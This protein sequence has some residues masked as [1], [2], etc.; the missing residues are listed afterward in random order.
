M[1]LSRILPVLLTAAIVAAWNWDF[2]SSRGTGPGPRRG[3]TMNLYESSGTRKAILCGGIG[4]DAVPTASCAVLNPFDNWNFFAEFSM[5]TPRTDAV[6]VL[7]HEGPL[8]YLITWGGTPKLS[9]AD[10]C[11]IIVAQD[12]WEPAVNASCTG[13]PPSATWGTTL[14]ATASGRLVFYGGATG[15]FADPG[16]DTGDLYTMSV[17][18]QQPLQ[19]AWG[20]PNMAVTDT[21]TARH[22]HAAAS[23]GETVVIFGGVTVAGA[24]LSDVW[25]LCTDCTSWEWQL[26]TTSGAPGLYGHN[27]VIT[28]SLFVVYGGQQP[29]PTGIY[30]SPVSSRGTWTFTSPKVTGNAPPSGFGSA[31]AL[32]AADG[33]SDPDLVVYGGSTTSSVGS[34][35]SSSLSVLSDIGMSP[36]GVE[37][38]LPYIIGGATGAL[39]LLGGI[40]ICAYQ[41]QKRPPGL[42]AQL[43]SMASKPYEHLSEDAEA[44]ERQLL[45]TPALTR[46]NSFFSSAKRAKGARPVEE[47]RSEEEELDAAMVAEGRLRF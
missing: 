25:L 44:G 42:A 19:M 10:V 22:Y 26:M 39:V 18:S 16:V 3:H 32:L 40:G 14:T 2:P 38:E 23:F 47:E 9:T 4:R 31:V 1:A 29:A 8:N 35:P 13:T 33:D 6:S 17:V 12:P 36:F 28:G 24:V 7:L 21:P 41:R 43:A 15:T 20:L 11:D 45:A 46:S 34:M 30:S 27:A 5:S 37:E